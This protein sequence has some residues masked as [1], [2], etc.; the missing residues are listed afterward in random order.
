MIDLIVIGAGP[1]GGSL[2]AAVAQRGW[3]VLLLER[4]AGPHHKVCGEF[5]SPEVQASLQNLG[6]YQPIAELQPAPM[7]RARLFSRRGVALDFDLP[8]EAW[9]LSRY[10]LDS[11]LARAATE[12]GATV[13]YGV[14]ATALEQHEDHY[15]VSIRADQGVTATLPARAVVV[16]TGRQLQAGLRSQPPASLTGEQNVGVKCHYTGLDLAPEVR[17]YLFEGGYIGLSPIEGGRANLCLLADKATFQRAGS[18][19]MSM[20]AY[21]ARLNSALHADLAGGTAMLESAVAVGAVDTNRVPLPW[22]NAPRLGDAVAMIPP[23]CGDGMAMAIRAAELCVPQVD[24]Y[25]RGRSSLTEWER[26]HQNLWHAEFDRTLSTGR[27][28]QALLNM[29]LLNDSMLG[30]GRLLPGLTGKLVQA[31]RS[32][33]Q[34]VAIDAPGAGEIGRTHAD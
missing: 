14:A 23:L 18:N 15:R 31:T 34:P 4:Q 10:A 6:L 29:P 19:V 2:A 24:A 30:L 26:A 32:S 20:L 7:Q 8:G 1:A 11:A 33:H 21:A 3:Q 27:R 13:L 5:L 25:L 16:A 12:S 28:L 22:D 9:G 17:L